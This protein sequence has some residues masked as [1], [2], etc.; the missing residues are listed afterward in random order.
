MPLQFRRGT[1]A[2]RL[3]ITPSAGEPI[4][5]TNTN[6]L[7]VGDGVTPGGIAITGGGTP[8]NISTVTNQALF[9]TSSVTFN[10]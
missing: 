3:T 8:F 9:T 6:L 4:W 5:T 7:Y 1:N 2:Q 10:N